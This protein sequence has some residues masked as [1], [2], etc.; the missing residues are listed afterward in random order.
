[1]PEPNSADAQMALYLGDHGVIADP[2]ALYV[3]QFGGNDL[4]DALTSVDP[5]GSVSQAVAAEIGMIKQLADQGA[6]HF[7]VVNAPDLGIVP[8]INL[9]GVAGPAS[10]LSVLYN[11]FLEQGIQSLEANP[12]YAG[13][14]FDRLDL[15]GIVHQIVADPAAFKLENT[16][17]PCLMFLPPATDI[18]DEPNKFAFWDG[19]HPT[20]IIHGIIA[21]QAAAIYDD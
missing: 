2:D 21:E 9:M 12:L 13:V 6:T 3:I 8:V 17:A 20:K 4:R 1:M 18:C 15:F 14:T 16:T 5:V 7:L 19:I 11:G 10:F